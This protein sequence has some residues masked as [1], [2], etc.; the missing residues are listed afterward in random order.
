MKL[1]TIMRL[2]EKMITMNKKPLECKTMGLA[3][4]KFVEHTFND[5]EFY[6]ALKDNYTKALE[7]DN[8]KWC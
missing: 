6:K 1:K 3:A 5:N 4:R 2:L 7:L 8:K